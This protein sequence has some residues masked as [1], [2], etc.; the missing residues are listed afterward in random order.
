MDFDADYVYK[1]L[2]SGS[3]PY[4]KILAASEQPAVF[5]TDEGV[6]TISPEECDVSPTETS[7]PSVTPGEESSAT[8]SFLSS[9]LALST[10]CLLPTGRATSFLT[11][12]TL[13]ASASWVHGAGHLASE[14]CKPK[15]SIEIGV[16]EMAEVTPKFGET[17]H[18]LPANYST[19][20]WGYYDPNAT[21]ATA[22]VSMASGETITIEVITHHSGH[23]YAKMI[24]GDKAVEE[25]FAWES[26]ETAINKTEPKMPGSG[27]HLITGPVNI[28]GGMP[29]DILQVD[30]LELDPRP[31]PID[32]RT[33]GT[34]SQ[35]FAGYHFRLGEKRDGTEYTRSGGTEA[36]TV[37]EFVQ[38]EDDKMLYGKPVYMYRFPNMTNAVGDE[39]NIDNN[40]AV[41]VPQEFNYGYDLELLEEEPIAY[42]PGFDDIVVCI[43][44]WSQ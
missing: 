22:P 25:I 37:F 35:K 19:V 8:K 33:F 7:V 44:T 43:Q 6:L 9:T 17:D 4:V 41:V 2:P 38:D 39:V 32:G 18:Y 3:E 15:L 14:N 24:R 21:A 20:V 11:A 23:D 10:M 27:V 34:N 30:I 31:G 26:T 40:P 1:I 29:G 36:I 42:P 16:P 13:L 12:V 28:E 5:T